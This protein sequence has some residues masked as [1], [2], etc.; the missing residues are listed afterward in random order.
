VEES[1][2]AKIAKWVVLIGVIPVVFAIFSSRDSGPAVGDVKPASARKQMTDFTL[3]DLHGADWR[4]GAHRGDV[5]LVNFWATW[6]GPCREETP[7]LVRVAH[8]YAPKGL[9]VAGITMDEDG[10]ELVRKFAH[11]FGVD[12]PILLPGPDFELA[13]R[14]SGLPTTLLID[15]K[16]RVAKTYVGPVREA[17]F[18]ADVEVLL[19]EPGS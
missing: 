3:R 12:Y 6:C 7:G 18:R 16:G 14:V 5:V 19:K 8:A 15:R 17:V 1:R 11:D 13:G 10:V 4:L 2:G 9:S